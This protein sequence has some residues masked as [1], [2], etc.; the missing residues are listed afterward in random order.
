MTR[1]KT[2]EERIEGEL[3]SRLDDMRTLYR[4]MQDD[5]EY[6]GQDAWDAHGDYPLS[7]ELVRSVRVV[8]STGGPHD[9]FV[10]T[11]DDDGTIAR[12]EYVYQD[13]FDGARRVLSGEE[14]DAAEAFLAPYV[15]YVR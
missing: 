2:C 9:E 6:E 7:V 3:A 10:V 5:E 1:D 13:W 12:I 4:A 15:E 14:F 11:L 8:L